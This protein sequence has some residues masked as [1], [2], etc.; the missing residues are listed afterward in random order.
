M[1][2]DRGA[3]EYVARIFGG[4]NYMVLD[5]LKRLPEKLPSLYLRLTT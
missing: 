3:D 5:Q 4:R 2:L 1:T